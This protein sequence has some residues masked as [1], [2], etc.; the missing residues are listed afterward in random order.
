MPATPAVRLLDLIAGN[1]LFLRVAA[2]VWNLT[3]YASEL[4]GKCAQAGAFTYSQI[5][6]PRPLAA[7][8]LD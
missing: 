8:G 5:A 1:G 7:L 3:P 6:L 4:D 2:H